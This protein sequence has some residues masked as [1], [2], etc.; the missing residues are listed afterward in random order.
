MKKFPVLG[1]GSKCAK[2]VDWSKLDDDHARKVHGQSL[3]TLAS[4][5]GL[6]AIEIWWNVHKLKWDDKPLDQ[7]APYECVKK[8]AVSESEE[9]D[10]QG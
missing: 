6:C 1:E 2:Y 3:Q 7:S 4:R 9:S 10:E 8:I 5:G